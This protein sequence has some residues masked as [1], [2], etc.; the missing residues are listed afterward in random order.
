MLPLSNNEDFILLQNMPRFQPEN[1]EKNAQIFERVNAMAARKGCTPS[2]LALAWVHHQ[3]SDVCPIPG[4][5]K[6]ENFNQNVKAMS[7]K[8]T[9]DEMAELE[10][11]CTLREVKSWVTGML[12]W[13]TLGRTPRPCH[14]HHGNLSSQ[15]PSSAEDAQ[16]HFASFDV[17][18]KV[19]IACLIL[20]I[21]S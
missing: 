15:S 6:I 13:P 10:S 9:P 14:Y 16:V 7:V 8:L 3:G 19:R 11:Y 2:Q 21:Y 5:T 1:L 12:K 18:Y 17:W 4:T 20:C